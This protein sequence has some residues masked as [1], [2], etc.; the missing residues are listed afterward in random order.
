MRT[1]TLSLDLEYEDQT[2]SKSRELEP[3]PIRLK[4]WETNPTC[5]RQYE[6]FP[7]SFQSMDTSLLL[8]SECRVGPS[9]PSYPLQVHPSLEMSWGTD[10]ASLQ[11]SGPSLAFLLLNVVEKGS[12]KGY[13]V[14][15]QH[16]CSLAQGLWILILKSGS[17]IEFHFYLNACS[18]KLNYLSCPF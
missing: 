11:G 7:F 14:E 9:S 2:L 6:Y 12:R 5:S 18:F 3:G 16:V 15:R 10:L 13:R 1:V 4:V 8:I 17:L